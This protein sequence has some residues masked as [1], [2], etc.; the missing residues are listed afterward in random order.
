MPET[1]HPAHTGVPISVDP[2]SRARPDRIAPTL[3]WWPAVVLASLPPLAVLV[4]AVAAAWHHPIVGADEAV[5]EIW[6]RAALNGKALLGPYSRFGWHHPGPTWFYVAAAFSIVFGPG[7]GGL[8][9]A[10]AA[11]LAA[12][13]AIAVVIVG[14]AVGGRAAWIASLTLLAWTV[15]VGTTWFDNYWNPLVV[16]GPCLVVGVAAAGLSA[17]YGWC[18]PLIVGFGSFA[19]QTHVGSAPT[20]IGLTSPAVVALAIGGGWR[21][22]GRRPLVIG[23]VAVVVLWLLPFWEQIRNSPGNATALIKFARE[24]HDAHDVREVARF[25]GPQ[26]TL[27]H[28]DLV[29]AS[30]S[31]GFDT[32]GTRWLVLLL[33]A[34]V[35]LGTLAVVNHRRGRPFHRTL[36]AGSAVAGVLLVWSTVHT[37]D[38]AYAYLSVSAVA[39]GGIAW[40]GIVLT[41]AD[42]ISMRM[43]TDRDGRRRTAARLVAVMAVLSV[44]L[45][46][47]ALLPAQ[48]G[49]LRALQPTSQAVRSGVVEMLSAVAGQSPVLVRIDA[50]EGWPVAAAL[51]NQIERAGGD[52]A[53]DEYWT[54]M[55]GEQHLARGCPPVV[56]RVGSPPEPDAPVAVTIQGVPAWIQPTSGIGCGP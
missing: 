8:A 15:A 26:I 16:I 35:A 18:L 10:A 13:T 4:S 48:R 24:P 47:H 43:A 38:T 17:G 56:I 31:R 53:V 7:V 36:C 52:F 5:T 22:L 30:I 12:S 23:L 9:V 19:V 55:F 33:I 45:T 27:L 41:C 46:I 25:L 29:E 40:C 44:V 32:N 37:A 20:V 42:E 2:A 49:Q 1:H 54:F 34:T 14:H 50:P 51:A 39:V 28:L 11:V 6:T 21:R 3:R